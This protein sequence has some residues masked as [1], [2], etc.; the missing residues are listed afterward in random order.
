M[1]FEGSATNRCEE[2]RAR[3]KLP[4]SGLL[5][6]PLQHDAAPQGWRLK[7]GTESPFCYSNMPL[8]A[9]AAQ[10]NVSLEYKKIE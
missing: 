5:E 7:L 6:H 1:K 3:L 8:L 9:V 10:L 4:R 2:F